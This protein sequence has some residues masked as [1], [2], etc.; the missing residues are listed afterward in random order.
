MTFYF[1]DD[2]C[3]EK[4]ITLMLMD[5]CHQIPVYYVINE[6]LKLQLKEKLILL[7]GIQLDVIVEDELVLHLNKGKT[8]IIDEYYHAVINQKMGLNFWEQGIPELFSKRRSEKL[9]ISTDKS[10]PISK[11]FKRRW[12]LFPST[13]ILVQYRA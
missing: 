8:F 6:V 11:I 7:N 3:H 1:N 13:S 9:F 12:A 2:S 10:L 5:K 4:S